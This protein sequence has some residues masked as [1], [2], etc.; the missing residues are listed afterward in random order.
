MLVGPLVIKVSKK[1]SIDVP[2]SIQPLKKFD[3]SIDYLAITLL[4]SFAVIVNSLFIEKECHSVR[5]QLVV[6]M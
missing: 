4:R 1:L 5:R 3:I 6:L 2:F